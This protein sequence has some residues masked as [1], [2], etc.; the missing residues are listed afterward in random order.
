MPM[1]FTPKKKNTSKPRYQEIDMLRGIAVLAMIAFHTAFIMQTI[2][3]KY[4]SSSLLFWQGI[5]IL[6][7]GTFL[8]LAGLSL[9]IAAQKGKYFNPLV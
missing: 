4:V 5:P 2:F 1:L 3:E 8:T 7:G 6:I 9:Y